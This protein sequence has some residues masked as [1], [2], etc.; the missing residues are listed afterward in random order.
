MKR[1]VYRIEAALK[2]EED[3]QPRL[4]RLLPGRLED[5]G[6]KSFAVEAWIGREGHV[7]FRKQVEDVIRS[8]QWAPA[9]ETASDSL[10]RRGDSRG[11]RR[12]LVTRRLRPTPVQPPLAPPTAPGSHRR[13]NRLS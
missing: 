10:A 11:S 4:R 2:R 3:D 5:N 8:F 1:K 6:L 13:D 7:L 9:R 12:R